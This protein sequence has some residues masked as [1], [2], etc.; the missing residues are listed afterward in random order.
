MTRTVRAI[1]AVVIVVIIIGGGVFQYS[2]PLPPAQ[3]KVSASQLKLPGQ[4]SVSF[5]GQGQ[6]AVGEESLG[7]VSESPAEQPV[8]IASLTKIMTAYL[9]LQAHPLKLGEDGPTTT[10]TAADA[11][12]Y[13]RDK[14]AGDSVLQVSAG[15]R[16]TEIQL[17]EGLLLPSG[18]NVASLIANE[19]AGNEA[20]FVKK[21]NAT[22][23]SLGMTQ[24][25]YADASGVSPQTVSTAHDQVLVAQAAMQNPVFRKIV[26]MPQ[27][28]LPVAG[29]VYNVNS[30]VGK[31]GITGIKTGS[32]LDAGGCFVGS[33]PITVDGQQ[34]I[35]I[36]AVLGQKTLE[37]LQTALTTTINML[38]QAAPEF[39][40]YTV[41]EPAQGFAQMTTAWKQG[42]DLKL[43]QPVTVFGYPGMPVHLSVNLTNDAIPVAAGQKMGTL[44]VTAGS[45][46]ETIALLSSKSITKPS[47]LWKLHR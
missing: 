46:T 18:D 9:L 16:L 31:H 43:A 11:Q 30:M 29:I 21:M 8:P 40:N 42:A 24:T 26:S 10:V 20:A 15:E 32:T 25:T 23:K 19:V 7:V 4:F 39:K 5:P 17:L 33:Y 44:K 28:D 47:T 14:Q 2:R 37:S 22:A 6:G 35:L 41:P 27:A 34:H 1:I 3:V 12:V 36:G 38:H 45:S 13:A